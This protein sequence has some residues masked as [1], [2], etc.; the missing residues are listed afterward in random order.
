MDVPQTV[1]G[2]AAAF[3][4]IELLVVIAIVVV[5]AVLAVPWALRSIKAAQER[6]CAAN[7]RSWGQAFMVF[8]A[9]HQG[10]L[11]HPDD[12]RRDGGAMGSTSHPEHDQG[13]IDLLP[14]YM[15]ERPWRDIPEGGKPR[16]G[17][18][19]CPAAR[20]RPDS[21]YDYKPSRQGYHSYAMNSYLA[22]DFYFGLPWNAEL[23]PS[24][25][26]LPRAQNTAVTIL[27]FEQTLDPGQGYGQAGSFRSAGYHTAED[28]RAVTERHRRSAEGLGGNVLYLDGHAGWRDDLWDETTRNPRIPKRGDL[29]WFPY[30]Y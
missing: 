17:V 18:W 5:L 22:H 20:P 10:L 11:P 21:D 19:Q 13:Y 30:E 15:G 1:K 26:Y 23:Q 6:A 4:L 24:F 16:A 29:T 25:L 14:P 28:A 7:L 2:R 8:A 27:M 9:E 3:T 12:R